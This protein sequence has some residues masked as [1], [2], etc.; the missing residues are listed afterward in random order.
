MNE[1]PMSLRDTA[2]GIG[3]RAAILGAGGLVIGG[4]LTAFALKAAGKLVHLT[5]GLALLLLSAGVATWELKKVQQRLGG[6]RELTP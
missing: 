2:R 3:I 6:G 4:W 1:Q 5:V